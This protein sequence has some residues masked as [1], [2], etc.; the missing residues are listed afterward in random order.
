MMI[1]NSIAEAGRAVL[2]ALAFIAFLTPAQAQQTSANAIALAKEIIVLKGSAHMFDPVVPNLVDKTKTMLMQTNPMLSKDLNDVAAKLRTEL[3]PRA[4]E[5]LE[6]MAKLYAAAFTEQELKDA[7]AFYK[8]AL[9]KKITT[10][11]PRIL[12]QAFEQAD[13]WADK[14]AEEVISRMR[15]EMKKKGHDL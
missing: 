15:A 5:L 2:M 13:V 8:S 1:V 6:L 4:S 3:A 10:T 7:L 11:E 9:G 12:E 14:F